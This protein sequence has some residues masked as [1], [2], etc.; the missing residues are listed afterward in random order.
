MSNSVVTNDPSLPLDG[1]IMKRAL[2]EEY[3][4]DL[5][6][7]LSDPKEQLIHPTEMPIKK[8]NED[9]EKW[10]Y[11][12]SFAQYQV[13]VES[14]QYWHKRA[15]FVHSDRIN[16]KGRRGKIDIGSGVYRGYRMPMITLH[17]PDLTWW[18]VGNLSSIENLLV[19]VSAIGKKTGQGNG[20]VLRWEF[21][22]I[23]EDWSV[24]KG[25]KYTRAVPIDNPND[26]LEESTSI[27]FRAYRP[28]YWH[29]DNFSWCKQ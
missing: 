13:R 29:R 11:A 27:T 26:I 25:R 7:V 20:R 24:R 2:E 8:V 18:L 9:S 15:D 1:I 12:S 21:E 6:A 28:P 17:I 16:W 4:H 23:K 5:Q 14:T 10:L 22:E 19:D 3:G